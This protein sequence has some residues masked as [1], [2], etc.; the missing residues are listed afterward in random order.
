MTF[1]VLAMSAAA[2]LGAPYPVQH[3]LLALACGFFFFVAITGPYGPPGALIF[4]F[5]ASAAMGHVASWQDV[6]KRMV[7]TGLAAGLSWMICTG[8]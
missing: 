6:L 1:A 2:W 5:A 7:A 3:G 8:T 4:A